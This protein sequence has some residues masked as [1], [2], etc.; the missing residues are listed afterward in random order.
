MEALMR[1]VQM[2]IGT[3]TLSQAAISGLLLHTPSEFYDDT[4]KSLKAGAELCYRRVQCIK[5]LDCPT[6]PQGAMY[7][8]VKINPGA[9]KGLSSDVEFASLLA[10]EESVLVLPGAAFGIANWIRVVFATPQN[11]LEEAWD[12]IELFCLRHSFQH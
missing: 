2:T 6:F 7:I 11:L 4:L 1:L 5:G 8:M 12:R 3:S 10:E 9:F